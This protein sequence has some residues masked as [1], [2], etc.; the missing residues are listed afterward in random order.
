M[1]KEHREI[2]IQRTQEN[3]KQRVF[4][5]WIELTV[6]KKYIASFEFIIVVYLFYIL[7]NLSSFHFNILE[8]LQKRFYPM[9][10]FGSFLLHDN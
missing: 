10:Y 6:R 3:Q 1:I 2:I 5:K 8:W 9:K 4:E 7:E